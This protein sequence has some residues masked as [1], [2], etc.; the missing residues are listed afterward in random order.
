MS[1][2]KHTPE[3][4]S[5]HAVWRYGEWLPCYCLAGCDHGIGSEQ[6]A[7]G[8]EIMV[9]TPYD[10]FTLPLQPTGLSSGPRFVVHVPGTEHPA[11]VDGSDAQ[12]A[13]IEA[14]AHEIWAAAQLAPGEGIVDGV[15]RVEALLLKTAHPAITH[16]DNCGCDWLDNGLNPVGCPYC[17]QSTE[18]ER[19]WAEL[20]NW[21]ESFCQA[22]SRAE[23]LAEA[24]HGWWKARR[25]V[26]W[27]EEQHRSCPHVNLTTDAEIALAT[28]LLRYQ[29]GGLSND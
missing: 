20:E 25:P 10:V 2:M 26:G 12:A 17:K 23:R 7:E 13:E 28:A 9:N 19:L 6:P 1:E 4:R 5:T 14:L 11:A 21:K 22:A 29:E 18:I 27:T 24:L 8:E 16:C 3:P 15:A